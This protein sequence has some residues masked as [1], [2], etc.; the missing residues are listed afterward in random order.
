MS[1]EGRLSHQFEGEAS[2]AERL[3]I[4]KMRFDRAS[5]N[6]VY[7]LTAEGAHVNFMSSAR[8]RANVLNPDYDA[9]GIGIVEVGGVLYV[10]EDFAHRVA[11]VKDDAAA[12]EVAA[13]FA[14][15]RKSSGAKALPL[16][17]NSCV[18][19]NAR[20]MAQQGAL[21]SRM[22]LR[23]LGARFAASYATT[24]LAQLPSDVARLSFV[25]GLSHYS[26]GVCYARSAKYP[27]GLYWVTLVLFDGPTTEATASRSH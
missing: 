19:Q 5:E 14:K 16:V 17:S 1:K 2:F 26:V 20:Y 27:G 8:H 15:L 13:E 23:L 11:E 4:Q 7:D 18:M 12:E 9:V 21:D 10:V 22:Q 3:I 6:V 25:H 24:N